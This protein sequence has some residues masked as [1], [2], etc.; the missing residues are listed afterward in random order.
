[1]SNVL[2]PPRDAHRLIAD[3]LQV[4]VD[5]D[6]RQNEPQVDRHRLLLGEQ[7]IGHLV[8]LALRRVDGGLI[9]L[10]VL[11]QT[12]VALQIGVHRGLHRLLRE[13]GHR[14]KLVL[15]LGELKL[16]VNTGHDQ[17]S[18]TL[19]CASTNVTASANFRSL[20]HLV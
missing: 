16:K 19:D 1:M 12:L 15:E 4:A 10:D 2:G 13:R 20:M 6:H 18:P 11:A 5:L 3:P 17:N 9:L 8:Q 14:K 7:L